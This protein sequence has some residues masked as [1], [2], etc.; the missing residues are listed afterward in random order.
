MDLSVDRRSESSVSVV[1]VTGEVDV[2]SAPRLREGVSAEL[3][4]D[5]AAVIVDL[6]EV[7]FLDS[8]G[9]GAL[10]SARTTAGERG[11][12][13]PVVCTSERIRKLFM[14]R[15]QDPSNI[16][17]IIDQGVEVL[18]TIGSP[19]YPTPERVLRKRVARSV[20]RSYC[21]AGVTRQIAK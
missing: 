2:H 5:A 19:A 6:S 18:R 21:P 13:M 10:V 15:A 7:G 3:A 8:T 12:L 9:L 14:R 17:S 16:E 20:R 11:V 4:G 1:S